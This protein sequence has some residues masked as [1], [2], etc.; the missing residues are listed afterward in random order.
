MKQFLI[1]AL[2][3]GA[4]YGGY[5]LYNYYNSATTLDVQIVD[6]D[7]IKKSITVR[8]INVGSSNIKIDSVKNTIL[9]NDSYIATAV[10]LKGFTIPGNGQIDV[11]F[12]LQIGFTSIGGLLQIAKGNLSVI[13]EINI[14]GSLIKLT[15]NIL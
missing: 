14:K 6:A 4:A 9:A 13:T 15:N 2:V 12:D 1:A 5:K 10:N 11:K 7:L 3:L 8:F